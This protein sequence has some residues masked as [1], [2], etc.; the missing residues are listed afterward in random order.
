MDKAG[1]L[2]RIGMEEGIDLEEVV[3]VENVIAAIQMGD[4]TQIN[5]GAYQTL[6]DATAE[7]LL[8]K[9]PTV[10]ITDGKMQAQGE[11]VKKVLVDGKPFFGD[12]PAAA[13]KNLPAENY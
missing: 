9:M 11:D 13:I 7:D 3:V 4:T 1:T 8:E 12:D 5:A 10:N 6:P 2:E